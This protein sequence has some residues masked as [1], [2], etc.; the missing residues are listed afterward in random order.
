MSKSKYKT[1]VYW[2][3]TEDGQF[4]AAV[5][6]GDVAFSVEPRPIQQFFEGEREAIMFHLMNVVSEKLFGIKRFITSDKGQVVANPQWKD[7]ESIPIQMI[8][9]TP[10]IVGIDGNPVN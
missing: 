10:K 6:V 4:I 7:L 2:T 8:D 3:K 5:Q 1:N 9:N